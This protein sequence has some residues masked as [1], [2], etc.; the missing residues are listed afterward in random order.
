MKQINFPDKLIMVSGKASSVELTQ[1][2]QQV[3]I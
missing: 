2:T 1:R 3:Y